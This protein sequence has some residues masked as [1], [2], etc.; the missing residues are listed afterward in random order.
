MPGIFL[1]AGATNPATVT[2]GTNGPAA[3]RGQTAPLPA[4][5]AAAHNL[6]P[7]GEV[8]PV[9]SRGESRAIGRIFS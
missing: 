6:S 9:A 8:G 1:Y 2:G 3:D 4:A 7:G 5:Q